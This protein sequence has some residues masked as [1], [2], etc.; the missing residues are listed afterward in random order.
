LPVSEKIQEEV[1]ALP[2]YPEMKKDQ[3]ELVVQVIKDF[4]G[5]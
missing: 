3:I 2:L 4:Q 1:I 5:Q